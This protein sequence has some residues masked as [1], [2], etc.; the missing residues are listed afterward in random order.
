MSLLT[1]HYREWRACREVAARWGKTSAGW[2]AARPVRQF[3]RGCGID[4]EGSGA[5]TWQVARFVRMFQ[6]CLILDGVDSNGDAFDYSNDGAE[7]L[8]VDGMAGALTRLAMSRSAE[9]GFMAWKHLAW[10]EIAVKDPNGKKPTVTNPVIH[11]VRDAVRLFAELRI[12]KGSALDPISWFRSLRW[13]TI[14]RGSTLSK[15]MLGMGFDFNPHPRLTEVAVRAAL[16]KVLGRDVGGVGVVE[17]WTR[18]FGI[19]RRRV[20]VVGPSHADVRETRV[21]WPYRNAA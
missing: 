13:N 9:A 7:R 2:A 1:H 10:R 14:I 12:I 20:S 17:T 8:I 21:R 4:I 19:W 18:S 16:L 15:H 6:D 11:S 3:M 5:Y